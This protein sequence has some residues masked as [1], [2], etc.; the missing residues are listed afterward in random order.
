MGHTVLIEKY[1]L[2]NNSKKTLEL[3][4]IFYLHSYIQ[5]LDRQ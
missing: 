2:K 1:F 5:I 3:K 4:L